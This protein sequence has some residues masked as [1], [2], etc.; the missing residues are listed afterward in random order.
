MKFKFL[1]KHDHFSAPIKTFVTHRDKD[2]NMKNFSEDHGSILG[3][4]LTVLCGLYTVVYVVNEVIKMNNEYYD[5]YSKNLHTNKFIG[6]LSFQNITETTFYP[7]LQLQLD[8]D[9]T[10]HV[11]KSDGSINE[12][13]LE[14]IVI[15][16]VTIRERGNNKDV[17]KTLKFR[18]CKLED[19]TSRN[20]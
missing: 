13:I 12:T 19:F 1:K 3:G 17:R 10:H 11:F 18:N 2:T 6:D 5:T 7:F 16:E 20:I 14:Q 9:D 8:H 15:P 4:I